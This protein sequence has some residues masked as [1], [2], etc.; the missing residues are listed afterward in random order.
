VSPSSSWND[1]RD[2]WPHASTSRFVDLGGLRWHI[3]IG[4]GRDVSV[5]FVHGS[6]ASTHSW[7][8]VIDEL[9]PEIGWMAIDLPGHGFSR[10]R[11]EL[12]PVGP[13][14]IARALRGLLDHTAVSPRVVVGHS[15]GAAIG[16][17]LADWVGADAV[18]ALNPSLTDAL[19]GRV[20]RALGE[21]VGPLVRSSFAAH[22]A[23]ALA[24]RTDWLERLLDGTGSD[25]PEWSRRCYRVLVGEPAH[26]GAV[27]RLFSR[28]KPD[29]MLDVLPSVRAHVDAVVGETDAWI[30]ADDVRIALA[31]VPDHSVVVMPGGHLAHE[32]HPASA[33]HRLTALL[34]R[35]SG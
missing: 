12:Q 24:R 15:A 22:L 17:V 9:P 14:G 35:V 31:N 30:P 19:R 18:L 25:V 20:E 2:W 21:V 27:L 3:Q 26:A 6:G 4:G 34:Q 1:V 5:L 11:P 33:A 8:G 29:E 10:V 28:W 23:S 13:G 7:A 32:E 16:L